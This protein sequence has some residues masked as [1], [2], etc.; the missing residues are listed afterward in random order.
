MA[1]EEEKTG[2]VFDILYADT[3]RLSSLLSQFS[4]DGVV[5]ELVRSAEDSESLSAGLSI[6][7]IRGDKASS[8]KETSARKVDPKWLLPLLFL[9]AAKDVIQRDV[10]KAAIGSLVLCQGKLV[11]TDLRILQKLWTSPGVKRMILANMKESADQAEASAGANRHEKRASA[12]SQ[13]STPAGNTEAEILLDLLPF[14]PHSPQVNIVTADYAVWSTID[15]LGLVGTVEDIMLKHGPKVAGSWSMVGVLDA[16]P[17]EQRE[18]EDYDDWLS[19]NEKLRIGAFQ[20]NV[21]KVAS[22]IARP[23]RQALGRPTFSYGVT[24]LVIFREIET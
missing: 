17:W 11:V 13:K 8:S 7:V 3:S 23:V 21:W 2:S 16:R 19:F 10:T 4:D 24:P 18:D 20:E 14:L 22:D 15:P 1:S 6:K 12:K 9:D 5:T